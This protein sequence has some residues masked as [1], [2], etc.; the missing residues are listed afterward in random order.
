[1]EKIRQVKPK[2][3]Y[4]KKDITK[5]LAPY[6]LSLTYTDYAHGKADDLELR[7]AD[8]EKL[9]LSDW[10]PVKGDKIEASLEVEGVT[11][12]C[13][14]FEVDEIEVSGPPG[15]ITIRAQ[16]AII[17]K[18]LRLTKRT[19]AWENTSFQAISQEI[20]NRAGL[21]LLF[22]G[23]DVQ[24]KRIDQTNESDLAFLKR[25]CEKT[26]YYLK[27]AGEKLIISQETFKNGGPL[28]GKLKPGELISWSFTDKTHR[29]YKKCRVSYWDPQKKQ[30]LVHEEEDPDAPDTGE[31]LVINERVEGLSQAIELAKKKLAMKNRFKTE[32]EVRLPGRPDLV[33]GVS[34]ELENFGVLSGKYAVEESRH[35]FSRSGYITVLKLRK[36]A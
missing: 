5:D 6:L 27:V 17:T 18:D 7:L 9:W 14:M 36:V 1:M 34:I 25:L 20:A 35:E 26:G 32:G 24:F 33:A 28:A 16:S 22:D 30:V 13:G 12:R 23:E 2:I 3:V 19:K 10:Y 31:V 15:E 4:S 21:T 29:I 11:L 8:P